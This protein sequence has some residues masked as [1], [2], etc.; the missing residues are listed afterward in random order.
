MKI[1]VNRLKEIQ[2]IQ[3]INREACSSR[4]PTSYLLDAP[5]L[6]ER[7]APLRWIHYLLAALPSGS[8]GT[9][10][11]CRDKRLLSAL[12]CCQTGGA[13]RR[14]EEDRHLPPTTSCFPRF[15]AQLV[16]QELP[17]KGYSR[18]GQGSR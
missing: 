18:N 4:V 8:T 14:C 17:C 11:Q 3:F 2:S 16:L 10:P 5:S 6:V 13:W 12:Q 9:T 1:D 7:T 15:E